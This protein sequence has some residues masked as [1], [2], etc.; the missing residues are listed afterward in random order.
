ML[1][2]LVAGRQHDQVGGKRF[3][4]THECACR[5]EGGDIGE[6]RQSD[7][8]FDDQIRTTDVEVVAAAAGEVLEL[9][10]GSV[11]AEIE[12]EAAAL[13]PIEQFPVDIPRGLCQ[14]DVVFPY[15]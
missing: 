3:A 9:P 1:L 13:E 2:P 12:L 8:A 15:Q 10:P 11:F 6:L 14:S 4:A 7:L 5:H